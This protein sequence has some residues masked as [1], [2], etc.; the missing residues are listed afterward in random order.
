MN[1][2]ILVDQDRLEWMVP[3]FAIT[4]GDMPLYPRRFARQVFSRTLR[5]K[6]AHLFDG[7]GPINSLL[8]RDD[9]RLRSMGLARHDGAPNPCAPFPHVL[10][11][12]LDDR[13]FDSSIFHV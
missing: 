7:E 11:D 6:E 9:R 5:R 1:D 8:R 10:A 3:Q 2:P 4:I 13:V 12:A